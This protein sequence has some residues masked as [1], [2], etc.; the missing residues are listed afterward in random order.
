MSYKDDRINQRYIQS[1]VD[2]VLPLL[3]M[4]FLSDKQEEAKENPNA[5]IQK[6]GFQFRDYELFTNIMKKQKNNDD[7]YMSDIK[8][9]IIALKNSHQN[10]IREIYSK[11]EEE[12]IEEELLEAVINK[13]EKTDDIS[14]LVDNLLFHYEKYNRYL[15]NPHIQPASMM[16]DLITFN[17]QTKEV[18]D[19]S[20]G[21]ARYII[22][23]KTFNK[24]V[25]YES[26][27]KRYI[28]ALHNLITHEIPLDNITIENKEI[29]TDP[30]SKRYDTII[31]SPHISR[32]RK[33]LDEGN[34][35]AKFDRNPFLT[36]LKNLYDHLSDEGKLVTSTT[37]GVMVKRDSYDFRK[38]LVEENHLDT[39]IQLSELN[40]TNSAILIIN[41]N[42]ETEDI[43]FIDAEDM[44]IRFNKEL[45]EKIINTYK[46]RKTTRGFSTILT[47]EQIIKNDYKLNPKRYVYN[48]EYEEKDIEL[49]KKE[50]HEY[51]IQ[52][53]D[54]DEKIND[55][56]GELSKHE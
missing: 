27:E 10:Y 4:K 30:D 46:K 16:S 40:P 5:F 43:L 24:A 8:S 31:S 41:K 47:K 29:I 18:Y 23:L 1:H 17:H 19:P 48:L 13:L 35:K 14:E 33:L 37:H 21:Y 51:T 39:I 55:L 7:T 12:K 32:Q 22:E 11:I 52:V 9:A 44:N 2:E 54:L 53:R 25:L 50:Q 20:C 36:Y 49:L 42:K 6:Y 15:H 45:S 28:H 38:L 56:L 3:T 26:E 34:K